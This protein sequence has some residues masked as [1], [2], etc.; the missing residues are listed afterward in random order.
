MPEVTNYRPGSFCW[1]EL[2]AADQAAA[3]KFYTQL[4]GWT[5]EDFPMGPDASYTMLKLNGKNVGALYQREKKQENVPAHWNC[6]VAVS[7]ADEAAKKV[8]ALGG[9][10]ILPPFDVF[11]A[12]RMTVLQDPAG[13]VLSLW[14]A[15]KH[16]GA[17]IVNEPGAPCWYELGTGNEQAASKFYTSLFGWSTKPLPITPPYTI[18]SN[19]GS[20]IGGMYKLTEQ[21]KGVPPHW[22]PYLQVS[23]CDAT[24]QKSQSLGG[25]TVLPPTDIPGTGRFA[26][27]QDPGGAV[28][29]IF[30]PSRK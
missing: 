26:Y 6:Y 17:A 5:F 20:D 27:L 14:Q 4:F 10:T 7:N 29:A 28:F 13:A 8:A 11:E 30:T 25:S 18:F 19:S 1:I 16:P 21:M 12:G 2:M 15:N 9:K 24:A 22:L 23:D 3:K